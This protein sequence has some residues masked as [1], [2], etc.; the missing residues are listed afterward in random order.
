MSVAGVILP[1]DGYLAACYAHVRSTN[2]LCPFPFCAAKT[3]MYTRGV[4]RRMK[5]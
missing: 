2:L 5:M 4:H 1:P 3:P